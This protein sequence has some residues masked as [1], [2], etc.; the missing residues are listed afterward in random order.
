MITNKK[1]AGVDV[2]KSK[3]DVN[4][5][6]NAIVVLNQPTEV[7]AMIH[8]LLDEN[9]SIHIICEATGGYEQLLVSCCHEIGVSISVVNAKKVRDFA[10]AKG[11]LAKTDVIDAGIIREYSEVFKPLP[12]RVPSEAQRQLSSAVRRKAK[13]T[14]I[15]AGEKNTLDKV[16]D[17]FVRNDLEVNIRHLARRLAECEKQIQKLIA[18]DADFEKKKRQMEQI[19]GVGPGVSSVLIAEMPELG[20]ISDKK[21][22]R[23][24]GVAP[25][26]RDSGK[27][28]GTRTI[29]GGRSLVRRSLYMPALSAAMH[30]PVLKE[31][32]QRLRAQNKPH[33]V[34]LTA[35]IRKLI[36]LINKVLSDPTFTPAN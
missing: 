5:K 34:A 22:A 25:L 9:P 30:N 27:W 3:L 18:S 21:A 13:L 26:N 31:F 7:I 19:K 33:H 4:F 11:Q 28:R 14:G 1:Y 17:T 8:G 24:V 29:H 2:C 12:D 36:C 10:S 32:Y 23:L 20:M 35:V 16:T 15:L 6:D